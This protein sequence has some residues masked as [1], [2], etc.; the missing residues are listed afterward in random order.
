VLVHWFLSYRSCRLPYLCTVGYVEVVGAGP[1]VPVVRILSS[2][3]QGGG[4]HGEAAL[5]PASLPAPDRSSQ[6]F[7]LPS[8]FSIYNQF[9]PSF[10][11]KKKLFCQPCDFRLLQRRGVFT[12][13]TQLYRV[14]GFPSYRAEA[15]FIN[16]Q[17]LESFRT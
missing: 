13:Q 4:G 5:V 11:H 14:K 3:L 2:S 6:A 16:A 1:L 12:V 7:Y 15:K 8:F 17:F 9:C 10:I